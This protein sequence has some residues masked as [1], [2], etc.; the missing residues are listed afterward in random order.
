MFVYR[1]LQFSYRNF[2][3]PKRST[4]NLSTVEKKCNNYTWKRNY[5]LK[6]YFAL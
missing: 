1:A 3:E 4:P 2:C 5:S 6:T